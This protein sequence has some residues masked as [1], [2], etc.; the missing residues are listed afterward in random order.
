M[1][2]LRSNISKKVLSYFFL[3]EE[4]ELYLNEMCRRFNLDRANLV[5]KLRE[6]EQEGVLK[7]EWKGNQRY[8]HLNPSFPLREEYKKIIL[9]TVGIE[10]TLQDLL[11]KIKGVRKAFLFGSYAQ[12]QMDAASDLDLIVIGEHSTIDLQREI[13][14]LQ[15]EIDR[16]INVI[17]LSLDEFQN[18][19][20]KDPFFQRILKNKKIELL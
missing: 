9:K 8:Y 5:R 2:S 1:L 10:Q 18:K 12:S 7:S 17:S 15:K 16:E 19:S 14:R 4:K 20:K 13:A 11:K 6:F 3:H